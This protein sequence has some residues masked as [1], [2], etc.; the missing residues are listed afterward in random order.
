MADS[1]DKVQEKTFLLGVRY[2]LTEA[3]FRTSVVE[4]GIK[5]ALAWWRKY[6]ME[7]G[8]ARDTSKSSKRVQLR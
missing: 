8:N 7:K 1:M 6:D 4:K 2:A 3:G 5:D